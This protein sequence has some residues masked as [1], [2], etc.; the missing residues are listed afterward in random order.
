MF[1]NI[2]R[3]FKFAFSNFSRNKGISVATIFVL[4]VAIL[5]VSA[6]FFFQ[7]ITGYLTAEIR[8]K[9]DIAAYFNDGTPEEDILAVKD[10]I[11]KMSPNI[12]SI[13]YV[14]KEQALALFNG[15]HQEDAVL[16]RALTEVG[17]NPFLPSLNITTSG[18]PAQYEE[19]SNA[20][21]ASA[22][23]KLIYKVDFSQKKDTIDKIYSITSNINMV[24]LGLGIVL[25][26]LSALVVFNTIKLGIDSSKD[27]ISTMKIVGASDW[28]VRGPF[29]MEG[30]IYGLI[31]FVICILI[32]G[33]SAYALSGKISVIMPGFSLFNYFLTNFW[34]FVLIQL[35]FGIGVGVVSSTIVVKKYLDI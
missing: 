16:Q 17:G 4:V 2:T 5:L 33:L 32:S 14:S 11:E 27:E 23:S 18:D 15:K 3:V 35:V 10:E 25:I 21:Q 6:L 12:K 8:N 22:F 30:I 26:I 9:I 24:G 7:G 13:E 34:I 1:T 20:I 19:V 29:I 31:A 28:F